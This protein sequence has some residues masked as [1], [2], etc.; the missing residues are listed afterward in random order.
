MRNSLC[1][2]ILVVAIS[3]GGCSNNIEADNYFPLQT[4]LQWTYQV[5]KELAEYSSEYQ[6]TI[7]NIATDQFDD[8]AVTIRRT[9][10]GT[11]YYITAD[12]TGTYRIAKRHIVEE[13]PVKDLT[14]RMVLPYPG[15]VELEY[16]W[17]SISAPY[18]LHNIS[19]YEDTGMNRKISI[20]MTYVLT[21]MDETV[22]VPA[23]QFNHCLRVEGRGQLSMYADAKAGYQDIQIT[24]TEWYAP[25]VGLVKLVR[26][27]PLD[28]DVYKGGSVTLELTDFES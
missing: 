8:K 1:L 2:F 4:G 6:L 21:A 16:S 28:T 25:A 3:S 7:Q 9:S 10:Q 22:T 11:D 26:S 24:T 17:N 19:P 13:S 23:G 5:K 20:P 14:A 12:E 15:P 18:A 27:E